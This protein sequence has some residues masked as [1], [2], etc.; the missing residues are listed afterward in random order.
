MHYMAEFFYTTILVVSKRK[1]LIV[2]KHAPLAAARHSPNKQV[3]KSLRSP[4][5][6]VRIVLKREGLVLRETE[7][8]SCLRQAQIWRGELLH[9][10]KDNLQT[11]K[12]L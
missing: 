10:S 9:G 8:H 3:S 12:I 1:S 2:H 7:Q 6:N 11:H 5:T 4:C